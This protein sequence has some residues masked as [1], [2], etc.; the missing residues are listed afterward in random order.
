MRKI[1]LIFFTH[2]ISFTPLLAQ[3][4]YGKLEEVKALKER[5]LIVVMKELSQYQLKKL[6]KKP[7]VI[8]NTE[9]YYRYINGHLQSVV[10]KF[11][12]FN[13]KEILYKTPSQIQKLQQD[14]SSPYAVLYHSVIETTEYA[15]GG[16]AGARFKAD[17]WKTSVMMIDLIENYNPEATYIKSKPV[18]YTNLPSIY[19]SK[20]DLAFGTQMIQN[21]L[22]ARLLGKNRKEAMEEVREYSKALETKTLLLA[23]EDMKESLTDE[24]IKKAYPYSYQVVDY[25]TIEEAILSKDPN[26][27]Y[28]III[29]MTSNN[30]TTFIHYVVE[31]STGYL[32]GYSAP[33]IGFKGF[34]YGARIKSKHLKDYTQFVSDNK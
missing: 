19:P 20:A 34:T 15:S 4:G 14:P 25:L 5:Q 29:P 3:F 28:V 31:A 13:N 32:I 10:P 22:E 23:K 17:S 30:K 21:Y 1:I 11:W 33:L 27:A 24:E 9:E 16:Y 7:D 2:I 6:R 8:K 26:V 18:Y 12:T